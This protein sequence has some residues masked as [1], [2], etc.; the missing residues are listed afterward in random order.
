MTGEFVYEK[1][2]SP[3]SIRLIELIPGNP[4]D[5]LQC[6]L[7]ESSIGSPTQYEAISYVWGDA[8]DIT[9]IICNDKLLKITVS[10]ASAL[11]SFRKLHDVRVLWADAICINQ[12]D[13]PERNAQVKLMADLYRIAEE[14]LIWL[15]P[16]SQDEDSA[17]GFRCLKILLGQVHPKIQDLEQWRNKNIWRESYKERVRNSEEI[18]KHFGIPSADSSEFTAL[19]RL[20]ARPWFYRAWTFQESFV[21]SKRTFLCGSWSITGWEMTNALSTLSRLYFCTNDP[22]YLDLRSQKIFAMVF[23]RNFW[24]RNNQRAHYYCTLQALLTQRRGSGCLFPIDLVYSIIGAASDRPEIEVNYNLP[25]ERVFASITVEVILKTGKLTI[26]SQVGKRMPTSLPSWVPDWRENFQSNGPFTSPT[27]TLY[28][29]TGS[30]KPS[31]QI[32]SDGQE[33]H[34][35]GIL[36][37]RVSGVRSRNKTDISEWYQSNLKEAGPT[38]APTG[39]SFDNVLTRIRCADLKLF[40]PDDVQSRWD[41]TSWSELE[42]LQDEAKSSKRSEKYEALI[43]K[44]VEMNSNRSYIVTVKGRIGTCSQEVKPGDRIALLLGGEVP[45]VLRLEG[46]G[47]YV[48]VCECFIYGFMDGE[49]LAEARHMAQPAYDVADTAWLQQLHEEPLPFQMQSIIIK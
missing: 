9:S 20:L 40:R 25:F 21:A 18:N 30:S 11:L 6:R 32:S 8:K 23:G 24:T 28:Y 43:V 12:Q 33:L 22:R 36:W 17:A 47:K 46:D 19:A 34:L 2:S 1:L 48:F 13:I 41:A 35:Q 10:L 42:A 7:V 49:G 5:T 39:E 38:Y 31:V 4:S 27:K 14:V 3:L 26:L 15:G 37:D 45:M 44:M 29:C 16:A